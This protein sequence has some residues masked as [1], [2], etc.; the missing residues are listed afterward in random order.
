MQ[1]VARPAPHSPCRYPGY[2][3]TTTVS[4]SQRHACPLQTTLHASATRG[5]FGN[6]YLIKF[7]LY[8]EPISNA[9]TLRI[10]ILQLKHRYSSVTQS[11]LPDQQHQHYR[12]SVRQAESASAPDMLNLSLHLTYNPQEQLS[13]GGL[14]SSEVQVSP[15]PARLSNISFAS[16]S[17]SPLQSPFPSLPHLLWHGADHLR[18]LPRMQIPGP[19]PEM[20]HPR[21]CIAKKWSRGS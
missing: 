21:V 9:N 2:R 18:S 1:E 16:L 7:L 17:L 6:C 4:R 12:E 13:T 10:K 3:V 15:W 11:V 20:Q 19:N 5:K 8:L 14:R